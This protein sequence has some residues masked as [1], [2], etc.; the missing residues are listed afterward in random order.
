MTLSDGSSVLVSSRIGVSVKDGNIEFYDKAGAGNK[1]YVHSASGDLAET[2]HVDPTQK[3]SSLEVGNTPLYETPTKGEYLKDKEIKFTLDGV[4]KT[5]SIDKAYS[6]QDELIADINKKLSSAFGAGKISV[7]ANYDKGLVF[8]TAKGSTMSI[9]GG[10]ALGLSTDSELSYLDMS[11]KLGDI[12][13]DGDWDSFAKAE[14]T[15]KVTK[16]EATETDPAYYVDEKGNR[17][18]QADDDNWYRIDEKGDFLYKFELNGQ[19]IGNFS[20]NSQLENVTVAINN[21]TTAGVNVSYSKTTNQF[22][23]VAEESGSAGKVDFGE[24]LAQ[25]LFGQG[26]SNV[27]KEEQGVDAIFSMSVDG[28]VYDGISRSSNTFNVDGMD[29]SLKG[30]FGEFNGEK[31][32]DVAEA[33]KDAVTFTCSADADKIVDAIK[34]MVEDYNAMVTEIKNAYSTM[35]AQKSNG[36]RY[37]P[38]S[39]K[40]IEGMTESAVKSYEE[41]AK[42]GI[43]FA[44]RDLSNLYS[45][46][47]SIISPAGQDGADLRA[48]GL[49][50]SYSNGLSVIKLDEDKLRAT[51]NTNPDKVKDAFTKSVANGAETDGLMASLKNTLE[52]YAKSTGSDKGILVTKAGSAKVPA[53]V[54]QNTLQTRLDEYDKQIE[55]WQDKLSDRVD[56]YT[57]QFTLLEQLVAEM[58]SQSSALMGLMGGMGTASV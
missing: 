58:N 38:L 23:F 29:I 33:E 36:S 40:D 21:N 8:T 52:V 5:I 13:K 20:K 32:Q 25:K 7:S 4:T 3:S 12:I 56:Y 10:K 17:V 42:E 27:V 57:K 47:T 34:T 31:L 26:G 16:V 6:D 43:L 22:H 46:L 51:L 30:T 9:E 11:K 53:S 55:K 1:V 19:T 15:G 41:K 48:M 2:L 18:E 28:N 44:D 37:E 39:D 54:Y 50:V 45:K 49:E 35:P 24:G 14:A